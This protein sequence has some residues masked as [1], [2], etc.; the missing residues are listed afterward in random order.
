MSQRFSEM[1]F[2][3]AD[4]LLLS[5]VRAEEPGYLVAPE[6]TYHLNQTLAVVTGPTKE[7]GPELVSVEGSPEYFEPEEIVQIVP[8][9]VYHNQ[10]KNTTVFRLLATKAP[11]KADMFGLMTVLVFE[12]SAVHGADGAEK[13]VVRL[14]IKLII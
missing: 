5:A 4:K 1:T 14:P 3:D 7:G 9:P 13:T 10:P 12:Y 2:I 8:P 6:R 11:A